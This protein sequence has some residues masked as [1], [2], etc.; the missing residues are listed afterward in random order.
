MYLGYY[1][2]L[3]KRNNEKILH[4]Q[5]YNLTAVCRDSTPVLAQTRRLHYIISY[6]CSGSVSRFSVD[7]IRWL[8]ARIYKIS[9]SS[10]VA[11]TGARVQLHSNYCVYDVLTNDFYYYDCYYI[12]DA[13]RARDVHTKSRKRI[14]LLYN[15]IPLSERR[16]QQLFLRHRAI[17]RADNPFVEDRQLHF[18]FT[19]PTSPLAALPLVGSHADIGFA[20]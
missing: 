15:I 9:K 10:V 1:D 20:A 2:K 17:P 19:N 13:M 6:R 14:L 3:R 5:P 12:I 4:R 18:L 7:I 8:G 11:H 16:L